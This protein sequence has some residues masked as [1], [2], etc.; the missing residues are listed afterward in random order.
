MLQQ[1]TFILGDREFTC[2][3]M[4]AFA[5]NK[6]LLRMQKVAVPVFGSLLSG[7]KGIAD[8]DVKE[9][10]QCIAMNIDETLMDSL[11]LPLFAES[12]LYCSAGKKFVK[13]AIDIDQCFTTENLF[14]LYELLFLVLRYQ[15]GPFFKTLLDRF[16]GLSGG[17]KQP[18]SLEN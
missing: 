2:T 1:E 3:R 7:G 14:E 9:A 13:T 16:G 10:A 12:K 11:V 5:A 17:T 15:F 6:L 8:I 4:N 18:P